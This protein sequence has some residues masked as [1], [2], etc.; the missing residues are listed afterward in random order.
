IQNNKN[1]II[2]DFFAGSGTTGHAVME[3]NKEDGGNRQCILCTNN[4]NNICE[5]VTY[6]R[7]KRVIKGYPYK[8]KEK[9]TLL[10]R[11]IS[12]TTFKQSQEIVEEVQELKD[13][14]EIKTKWKIKTQVKNDT[15]TVYAERNIDSFKEG[16]GG[17][18]KYYKT[19]FI[20][21]TDVTDDLRH[22]MVKHSTEILC[23]KEST[24]ESVHE[25]DHIKIYQNT[26]KY[27]AILFD[28]FYLKDFK[29]ELKK[30]TDK[31]VVIYVF[32]LDR[33]FPTI[34]FEDLSIQYSIEP[35]PEP[36]LETYKKIFDF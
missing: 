35:I 30:L 4:E 7:L 27:T 19:D 26:N 17:N 14:Y 22:R 31:P 20:P 28:L 8:G 1:A 23:I 16:L 33:H 32:S 3:L 11:K 24:Y 12:F 15:L 34:E 13:Q 29:E 2:L 6:E 5:E 9:K 36:I 21:Y 18:L 10:E 25:S